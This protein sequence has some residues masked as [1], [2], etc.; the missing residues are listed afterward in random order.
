MIKYLL[1]YN[2][3]LAITASQKLTLSVTSHKT[4]NERLLFQAKCATVRKE[5]L[6]QGSIYGHG[7]ARPVAPARAMA[8]LGPAG[9][10]RV[11]QSFILF[12]TSR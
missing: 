3:K 8:L 4:G 12:S 1:L 7:P 10:A 2:Q 6:E 9:S 5:Y 11:W